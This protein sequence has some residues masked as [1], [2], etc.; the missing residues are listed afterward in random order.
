MGLEIH[1]FAII[2]AVRSAAALIKATTKADQVLVESDY[3]SFT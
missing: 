1:T 2:K 3:D